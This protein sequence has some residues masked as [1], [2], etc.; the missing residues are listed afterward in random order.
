MTKEKSEI[1]LQMIEDLNAINN[2]EK[3]SITM[4]CLLKMTGLI[5]EEE[6]KEF[7]RYKIIR[8]RGKRPIDVKEEKTYSEETLK[9]KVE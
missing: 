6:I 8:Y 3:G 9:K 4:S 7:L 5:N 1:I 2:R